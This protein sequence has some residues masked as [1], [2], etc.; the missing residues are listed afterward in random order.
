MN[1]ATLRDAFSG[2]PPALKAR[3]T[4]LK[5]EK[6]RFFDNDPICR[7]G[8]EEELLLEE[9][10]LFRTLVDTHARD[11]NQQIDDLQ[12]LIDGPRERQMRLDGT[13]E[14]RT[15]RQ[16]ELQALEWRKQIK[17]LTEDLDHLKAARQRA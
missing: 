8:S 2:V 12:Q 14:E 4:R 1:L 9:L 7:Y 6:L 3:I 16:L 10:E 15:D 5:N 11:I 17:A 13:V